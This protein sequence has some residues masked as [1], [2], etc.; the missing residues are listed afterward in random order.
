MS[1]LL[2]TSLGEVV[3]DLRVK[4]APRTCLNFLKLCKL[5]Y[6]NNVLFFNV[7]ENLLVQTGDPT[8][9]GS[10][11]D[12]VFH[13]LDPRQPR[14]FPDELGLKKQVLT[15]GC[16]C[17]ANTGPDSNTSQFFVTMRDDDLTQFASNTLFG[18]VVEGLE[19]LQSISELYADSHGRPYQ[20]C[21]ILHTFVLDDPF[22]DPPGLVEP[23]SSPTHERPPTESVEVRL[24]VLDK[25]DEYEGKTEEE[26]AI[27]QRDREAKSRSVFLEIIGD[28]PDADVKPP[29]EVLFLCKLN[30]VTTAEDLELIFS[31][32]GPCTAHIILDYK[33]GDS[34]CFGFVEFT[35]KEHCIEA[36][37]KMNNVLIDDRRVKVDFSQSV[38]KL[39][40]KFRRNEKQS[41]DD[42]KPE[43]SG[44]R[45]KPLAKYDLLD[46]P[47]HRRD[48]HQHSHRRDEP[49]I[50]DD[51]DDRKAES[52]RRDDDRRHRS[53]DRS[54]RRDDR[55]RSEERRRS[56]RSRSRESRRK[57]RSRDRSDRR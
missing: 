13:V 31:R 56:R 36:C 10:G 14:A 29:E 41:K 33:T 45:A 1:V 5:K 16:L 52:R 47:A 50:K 25:L 7:Q 21:R 48:D 38:S 9:T 32:F 54:D 3:V 53:R 23:P 12:S 2:Q 43:S 15:K 18:H 34:L 11:G 8:G 4:E 26:V 44:I 42:T 39:W 27:M 20:D 40:N 49:K 30:P 46:E 28:L 17:M 24:S 6:Y 37:F 51:R 55:K 57:S 22:P 19:I 35:D